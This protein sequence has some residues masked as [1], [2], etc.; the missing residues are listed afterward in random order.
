MLSGIKYCVPGIGGVP[1]IGDLF[2]QI[3]GPL[4][5]GEADQELTNF[6]HSLNT[7]C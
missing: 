3:G 4:V 6:A 1:G 2:N 7:A 5:F